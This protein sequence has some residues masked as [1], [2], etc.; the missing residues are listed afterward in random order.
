MSKL[1]F[2][3]NIL[4]YIATKGDKKFLDVAL[5]ETRF[6]N[7]IKQNKKRFDTYVKYRT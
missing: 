3:E 4:E 6:T 7:H 5:V 2:V 1:L